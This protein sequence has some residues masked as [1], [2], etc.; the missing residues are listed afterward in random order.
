M[1]ALKLTSSASFFLKEQ[2]K[3]N[4]PKQAV[5][6]PDPLNPGRS[7][8]R[9]YP[10]G[11]PSSS[12]S[13]Q[14]VNLYREGT[15]YLLIDGVRYP[16]S[17]RKKGEKTPVWLLVLLTVCVYGFS[18]VLNT[19]IVTVYRFGIYGFCFFTGYFIFSHDE[20]V[21]RLSKWWGIFLIVAGATGIF[22]T[23]YYFG[24]N[25]AVAPVLN[26]LPACIYCGFSILAILAF[27]KKYGDAENKVSRWMLKKSWGI[28]VF[29]YLPL[30]CAAYYLRNFTSELPEGIVYIV[31]GISA[32]AGALLLYEIIRRI[33]IIC[34]CVL[35]LKKEKKDV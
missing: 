10:G 5:I 21:E 31:V 25:Y 7:I 34:W 1:H 30:A 16:M 35:G 4:A 27:M 9:C 17:Q 12:A 14:R 18:Q 11:T 26:N 24:E 23:I 32:F 19:P 6:Y 29:H 13:Q 8:I 33:P 28:Y 22:Y 3:E 20:V 15:E 2:K